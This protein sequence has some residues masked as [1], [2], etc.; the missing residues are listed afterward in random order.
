MQHSNSAPLVSI[1]VPV[2][3]GE[4]YLRESLDSILS[5]TYT[6][7][8]VIVMDDCSSDKTPAIIEAY[9][10]RVSSYRQKENKGQFANVNEG[11]TK[12]NGEY[13]SI[14]HADDI[15]SPQIVEHEAMF[16]QHNKEAGA[17]FS[18]DKFIDANGNEYG[19][20]YLP[21]ELQGNRAFEYPVIL[22]ALLKYKNSFLVGP[23]AMVRASVYRDVGLYKGD[24]F[25][26]ASD[27]EMWTRIARKYPVGILN[28]YLLKYR[29]GHGNLSQNYYH[30]R[31]EPEIHFRILDA[32]LECGGYQIARK[33]SLMA[34]EAHRAEDMLM[35]AINHYIRKEISDSRKCLKKMSIRNLIRSNMVQRWRLLILYSS[36]LVISKLPHLKFASDIFYKRWHTKK[37]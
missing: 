19:Q 25:K 24:E 1:V 2:Y 28:E 30:L 29:H 5:Q 35:L 11:I 21:S 12:A 16:L 37:Y 20:L 3:N 23:S 31:T 8:E 36:L 17:V 13:I 27:L 26:I 22:N 10:N 15:Y 33:E 34:H 7:T 4:R 14:F 18:L 32:H 9:G 6:N